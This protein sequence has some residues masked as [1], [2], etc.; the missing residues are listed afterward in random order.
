MTTGNKEKPSGSIPIRFIDDE[1]PNTAESPQDGVDFDLSDV[2]DVSL[3]L[4]DIDSGENRGGAPFG[5]PELAELIAARSE[6]KRLQGELAE[7]RDAVARRQADFENYRKRVERERGETFN[8]IVA[9]VARKLLPV[10][11]NLIRA[12]E[13][14]QTVE[15]HESK[16]FKHFL[17]WD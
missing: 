4:V 16:E 1:D 10:V 5:G 15:S 17:P 6:L 11:D 12:V 3:P 13:A 2:E 14:E 8:R 7:A 9:D